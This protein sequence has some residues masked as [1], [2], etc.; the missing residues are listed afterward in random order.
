MSFPEAGRAKVVVARRGSDG[1]TEDDAAGLTATIAKGSSA[2]KPLA[3]QSTSPGLWESTA[4]VEP[5]ETYRIAVAG[6]DGKPL[7]QH[8]FIGPPSPE[9]RHRTAD[10]RWLRRVA[11]QGGGHFEPDKLQPRLAPSATGE[12]LRLWPALVL[13]A[14]LLL[15]IDALLRRPA[16]EA[17]SVRA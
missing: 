4:A 11:A 16:R 12:R 3:L 9:R 17:R 10:E 8:T 14:L 7:A 13:L 2:A 5:G 6:S 15:P 1:L